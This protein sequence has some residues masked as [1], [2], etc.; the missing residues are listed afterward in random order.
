[1]ELGHRDPIDLDGANVPLKSEIGLQGGR[2]RSLRIVCPCPRRLTLMRSFE[3][4][5]MAR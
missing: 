4:K 1:M 3:R 5:R 2:K